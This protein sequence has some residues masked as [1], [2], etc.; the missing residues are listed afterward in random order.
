MPNNRSKSSERSPKRRVER[1]RSSSGNRSP[2]RDRRRAHWQSERRREPDS[3]S[4]YER[5]RPRRE[6]S[7]TPSTGQEATAERA[8]SSREAG[9]AE[10]EIVG[11]RDLNA[12]AANDEEEANRRALT[13]ST[14]R[15]RMLLGRVIFKDTLW[16]IAKS[17][18]DKTPQFQESGYL[19]EFIA[20]AIPRAVD[21]LRHE[22]LP[23]RALVEMAIELKCNDPS[24]RHSRRT[25][26]N[27]ILLKLPN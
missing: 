2:R 11:E 26:I 25:L 23:R 18:R 21:V 22:S 24:L 19:A 27:M 9:G 3:Y 6:R 20:H 13:V 1:R 4:S 8:Q 15:I 12:R 7:V 10:V 17:C 14:K 5:R 16:K